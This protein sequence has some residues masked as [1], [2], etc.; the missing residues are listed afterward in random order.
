MEAQKRRFL[1]YA[2]AERKG[3]GIG[4]VGFKA[5]MPGEE[6]FGAPKNAP[7]NTPIYFKVQIVFR[8]GGGGILVQKMFLCAAWRPNFGPSAVI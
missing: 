4:W 6:G 7:H 8:G 5:Q 3:T 2:C 1:G